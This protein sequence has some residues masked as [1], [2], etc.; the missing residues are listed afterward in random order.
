MSEEKYV[1]PGDA[2]A[3]AKDFVPGDGVYV[4]GN[5][6]RASLAG[7]VQISE[8]PPATIS[9]IRPDATPTLVP[10]VGSVVLAKVAS[11]APPLSPC[12]KLIVMPGHESDSAI[13]QG[14]DPMCGR[15]PVEERVSRRHSPGGRPLD[16]HRPGR[17]V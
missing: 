7:K 14:A 1:V 17:D 9:V 12:P 2:V 13:C 6:L 3:P 4:S 16:E 5:V 10:Q 8:G 11:L 15:S